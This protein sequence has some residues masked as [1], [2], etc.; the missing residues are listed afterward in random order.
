MYASNLRATMFV[1][2]NLIKL[3]WHIKR[4]TLIVEDIY[5]PVKKFDMSNRKNCTEM[6]KLPDII[7][8]VNLSK[9]YR[10][11]HP[12]T[13]EYIFFSEHHESY[14][15]TDH[16]ISPKANLNRYKIL[17]YYIVHYKMTIK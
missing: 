15:K 3:K 12:N 16:I 1:K 4:Q 2:D 10:I 5:I 11:F 6:M 17:K 9:T 8:Q 13:R 7:N 14:C